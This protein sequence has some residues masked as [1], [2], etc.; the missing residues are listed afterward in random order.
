MQKL[1]KVFVVDDY[2]TPIQCGTSR[3]RPRK[4]YFPFLKKCSDEINIRKVCWKCSEKDMK[5]L[6]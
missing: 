1:W 6:V 4:V 5:K 3:N 2:G